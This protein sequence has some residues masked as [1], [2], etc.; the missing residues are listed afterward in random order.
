MWEYLY[1]M[2]SEKAVSKSQKHENKALKSE[3]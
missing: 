2:F 1:K 3:I